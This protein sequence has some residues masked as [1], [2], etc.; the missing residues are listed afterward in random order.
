MPVGG[1]EIKDSTRFNSLWWRLE[2]LPLHD[3]PRLFQQ[4]ICT[5]GRFPLGKTLRLQT[6]SVVFLQ[7][8]S[9]L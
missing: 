4:E 5:A 2:D 7:N 8:E 3:A 9:G 1:V 6:L